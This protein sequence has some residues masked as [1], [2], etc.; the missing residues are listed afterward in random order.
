MA[1]LVLGRLIYCRRLL[2]T[3]KNLGLTPWRVREKRQ[4]IEQYFHKHKFSREINLG[5][6]KIKFKF[7][8]ESYS[9]LLNDSWQEIY[10]KGKG[11]RKV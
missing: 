1:V 4:F 6:E 11:H 7:E 5:C 2:L 3:D 9:A 8:N 10:Y